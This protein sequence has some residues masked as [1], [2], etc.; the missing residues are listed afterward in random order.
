MKFTDQARVYIRAGAGGNGCI[1][2]RREKFIEYGGP[3]GG[4]GGKGGNIIVKCVDNL[5]TLV[6]YKFQQHFKAGG[7]QHG[8]GSNCQGRNGDN[9]VLL[10]PLG[11]QIYADDNETLLA[12]LTVSG[13]EVL[14]LLG[15]NGG[16]GNARFKSSTNQAPNHANP[17]QPAQEAHIR[18]RLKLIADGGIIGMPNAGKSTFLSV[19]SNAR[20]KIAGYPF[21]TLYPNLGV[22]EIDNSRFV[23]ADIPGLI[24]GAGDGRGLGDRFLGHVERTSVL[25]HLLDGTEEN[26]V[27]N[28]Q[29]IRQELKKYNPDIAAKAEII[30]L[31]KCDSM[32]DA[33]IEF[34]KR[35][36]ENVTNKQVYLLSGVAKTGLDAILR[37]LHVIITEH[38]RIARE[39]AQNEDNSKDVPYNKQGIISNYTIEKMEIFN[40]HLPQEDDEDGK[41]F[42]QEEDGVEC[43]YVKG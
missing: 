33:D 43:I 23:L 1:S 32:T 6:D 19:I 26:V 11:T 13:Q 4:D 8:M 22:A 27:K 5:N 25:L 37:A 39:L 40:S 2:F 15:G 28:Y 9:K 21:T 20:P 42:D 16:W 14:L 17:G 31:N 10:L 3:N 35:Q 12:D 41:V 34:K 36:L 30:A 7:G 24:E 29:I 38:K 18:L